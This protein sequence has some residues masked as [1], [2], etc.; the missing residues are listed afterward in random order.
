LIASSATRNIGIVAPFLHLENLGK[1]DL[2][3]PNKV[4]DLP[5]NL[6]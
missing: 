6:R 3:A 2:D 1:L 4:H 5:E